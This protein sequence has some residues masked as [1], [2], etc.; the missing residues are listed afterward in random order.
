MIRDWRSLQR[1]VSF[2]HIPNIILMLFIEESPRWLASKGRTKEAKAALQVMAIK[3]G[4]YDGIDD[5]SV[6]KVSNDSGNKK[7][8]QLDMFRQGRHM[9]S[10]LLKLMYRRKTKF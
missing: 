9:T 2:V 10:V 6:P 3:N 7:Y 4:N 5:F 8:S 1:M